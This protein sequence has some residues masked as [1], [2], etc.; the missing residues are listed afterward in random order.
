MLG[1]PGQEPWKTRSAR[2][3]GNAED[4]PIVI[5]KLVLLLSPTVD[6]PYALLG[7][8]CPRATY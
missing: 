7:I 5:A 3:L 4:F 1:S 6:R 8:A 2:L